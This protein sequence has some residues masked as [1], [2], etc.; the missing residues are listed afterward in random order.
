M[1]SRLAQQPPRQA[2]PVTLDGVFAAFL[3]SAFLKAL[4]CRKLDVP[5]GSILLLDNVRGVPSG[6]ALTASA[7]CMS[8]ARPRSQAQ[9]HFATWGEPVFEAVLAAALAH[10]A[11]RCVQKVE[12][13]VH[14]ST[15]TL[16]S[17]AVATAN[18][19]K[20][21]KSLTDLLGLKL[22]ANAKLGEEQVLPWRAELQALA[23]EEGRACA[24]ADWVEASNEEAGRTE[25]AMHCFVAARLLE[26]A[27]ADKDVLFRSAIAALESQLADHA[28][29]RILNMPDHLVERNGSC[30]SIYRRRPQL[31]TIFMSICRASCFRSSTMQLAAR[32]RHC[33]WVESI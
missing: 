14:G 2:L 16:L 4:G 8:A 18:G 24:M 15:A 30:C 6:A 13:A 1:Y 33:E 5:E 23:R 9:L 7:S 29:V 11:P 31:P 28:V 26:Y 21:V 25:Q 20:L 19:V 10:D 32:R 22:D 12:V 3:R 17:Y 27:A